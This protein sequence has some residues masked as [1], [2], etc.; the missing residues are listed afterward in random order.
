MIVM[1]LIAS[2]LLF[3]YDVHL[4]IRSTWLNLCFVHLIDFQN[5]TKNIQNSLKVQV[6]KCLIICYLIMALAVIGYDWKYGCIH[7]VFSLQLKLIKT[8]WKE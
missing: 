1:A 8:E 2:R 3:F 5:A 6:L 7:S 4:C